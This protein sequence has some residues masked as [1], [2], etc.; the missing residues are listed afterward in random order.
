MSGPR[1]SAGV[2]A[3]AVARFE[4]CLAQVSSEPSDTAGSHH[5]KLP[6]LFLS[7]SFLAK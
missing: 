5:E 3:L 6:E 1:K 2:L 4:T 7:V